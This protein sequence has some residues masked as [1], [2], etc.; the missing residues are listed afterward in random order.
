VFALPPSVLIAAAAWFVLGMVWF[1]IIARHW[2]SRG[3]T[4]DP[5][6]YPGALL[7]GVLLLAVAPAV[8]VGQYVGSDHQ[9]FSGGAAIALGGLLLIGYH[10]VLRRP[11]AGRLRRPGQL[12]LREKG[13]IAEIVAILCVYG[14]YGARLW[15]QPL[16]S[17]T[18]TA[19]LIGITI[20]MIIIRIAF[21]LVSGAYARLERPDE[22]ERL[23]ALRGARNA[24]A[25]LAVGVWCIILLAIAR[26]PDRV[27]FYAALAAFALAELVRLGSELLYYRRGP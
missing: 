22:R 11:P 23:V 5:R 16:T 26:T 9:S 19:A 24:Y 25:A 1:I 3:R 2:L 7:N 13:I 12:S 10:R 27:L 21:H 14:F 6:A 17:I 15:G 20:L 8:A 18:A 4:A